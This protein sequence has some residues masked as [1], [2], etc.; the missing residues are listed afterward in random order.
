M[1]KHWNISK[2]DIFHSVFTLI[3]VSAL[4][5]FLY[6]WI[7]KALFVIISSTM[8]WQRNVVQM[9]R[10]C[11][12]ILMLLCFH[13]VVSFSSLPL[14]QALWCQSCSCSTQGWIEPVVGGWRR[15]PPSSCGGPVRP[16]ASCSGWRR[17]I[18]QPRLRSWE[19]EGGRCLLSYRQVR[20]N[21]FH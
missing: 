7:N 20:E 8:Q 4:D 18:L 14:D 5:Y 9:Y 17:G 3:S 10:L 15:T 16:G 11:S 6:V 13:C 2:R 12:H 19:T 1:I 21:S